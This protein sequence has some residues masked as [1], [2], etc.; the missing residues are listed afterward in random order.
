MRYGL[1]RKAVEFSCR[2]YW[3]REFLKV[4]SACPFVR[5]A[6]ANNLATYCTPRGTLYSTPISVS[7]NASLQAIAYESGM[8]DSAISSVTYTISGGSGPPWYNTGWSYRKPITIAYGQ[9]SGASSLIN[10][11]MDVSWASDSNLSAGAQSSGNDILFTA[12]DG[13]TKLNHEIEQYTSSTGQLASWVQIPSLSPT[14][15]TVIYMY[16]GN[17]SASNQQNAASV[18]DSNYKGVWH[19][20]QNPT[21]SAPQLLDSTSNAYNL[22]VTTGS[23][24]AA[25]STGQIG[26][27]VSFPMTNE[28]SPTY[29]TNSGN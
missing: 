23:A 20:P 28:Y 13:V 22:T 24:G 29:A 3:R 25:T 9:V 17:S 27:A 19:L 26:G 5:A 4:Q 1:F 12:S 15:N 14:A 11:P 10:F 8:A 21:G 16:Y 2:R 18:W 6:T 7:S